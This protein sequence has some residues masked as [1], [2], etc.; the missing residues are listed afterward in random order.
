VI[1]A[2]SKLMYPILQQPAAA[3][4][5]VF[6][7]DPDPIFPG[8]I[9]SFGWETITGFTSTDHTIVGNWLELLK[10]I[11]PGMERVAILYHEGPSALGYLQAIRPLAPS[12]GVRLTEFRV[13]DIPDI[14]RDL[15]S[16]AEEPNGGL[17]VLSS[18]IMEVYRDVIPALAAK[19]RL[20]SIYEFRL[21]AA[22]GGLMS[23]GPDLLEPYRRAASYVDRILKGE[24]PADLPVQAPNKFD[25][26]INL[27][28]A[29][30]LGLT[31]PAPLLAR[32]DE[33]IE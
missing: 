28:T 27:K 29:R 23:Y 12:F 3:R 22:N 19:H 21:F 8:L 32:A 25:L 15:D 7:Q 20:P 9:P 18:S 26:T 5:I 6:V 2:D 13:D 11:A 31:V 10:Q 24:R 16:F 1:L 4:P 14:R 30:S 17:V 33:V